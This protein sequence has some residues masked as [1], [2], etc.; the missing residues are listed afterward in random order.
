MRGTYGGTY[1]LEVRYSDKV[2]CT[3]ES[4]V[5]YEINGIQQAVCIYS[6]LAAKAL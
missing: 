4:T 2:L 1:R 5:L 6:V 3:S